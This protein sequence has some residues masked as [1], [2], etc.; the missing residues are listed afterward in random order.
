[1]TWKRVVASLRFELLVAGVTVVAVL[2]LRSRGLKMDG[3]TVGYIADATL[4]RWPSVLLLGLVLQ[5]LGCLVLWRSP[6]GWLRRFAEPRSLLAFAR[7]WLGLMV[8]TYT[9]LWLKI[10]VPLVNRA[11]WDAELWALD[12]WLHLGVSPTLFVVELFAGSRLV[13]WLDYWYALWLTTI[14]ATQ[15]YLFFDPD[16]RKRLNFAFACALL[17]LAAAWIY[18]ALPAVGP[19]FFVRDVFD[20]VRAAMPGAAALQD[21]LWQN[22][23][24]MIAGRDGGL[25]IQFKPFFAVAALPS[26]HV[27]AHFMFTLWARRHARRLWPLFAVATALTFVG[28]LL[29]GWHYAVD[30]YL[31][32]L[33]GWCAVRL[34]D[35][36]VPV[37]DDAAE[38]T[39]P[40]AGAAPA[41]GSARRNRARVAIGLTL[42]VYA[43]Y[44][45]EKWRSE[46]PRDF[47]VLWT[48]GQALEEMKPSNLYSLADRHAI[49][50]E[51]RARSALS[52]SAARQRSA[53]V[54]D[55]LEPV[56]TP[57][58]FATV[59]LVSSGDFETDYRRFHALSTL[60]YVGSVLWVAHLLGFPRWTF[61]AWALL[62]TWL[63]LPFYTDSGFANVGRIQLGLLVAVVALARRDA[64]WSDAL[65]GVTLAFS[66]LFKPTVVFAVVLLGALWGLEGRYRKLLRCAAAGRRGARRRPL[67]AGAA[68]RAGLQLVRVEPRP[69]R[70]P[71]DDRKPRR[72]VP[73]HAARAAAARDPAGVRRS[74]ALGR[75]GDPGADGVEA[76]AVAAARRKRSWRAR[77][78]R[79]RRRDLS[80]LG[81]R[82]PLALLRA[83]GTPGLV[84]VRPAGAEVANRAGRPRLRLDGPPPLVPVAGTHRGAQSQPLV[85]RR[86]RHPGGD[87]ARSPRKRTRARRARDGRRVGCRCSRSAL[88]RKRRGRPF[89]SRAAAPG[90]GRSPAAGR[91]PARRR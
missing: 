15:A 44:A 39:D 78:G 33:L 49:T 51:Y 68:L 41:A 6:L 57:F 42:C 47:Y 86:R 77:R 3:R 14:F 20:P 18:V 46:L 81:T 24:Q 63:F 21:K 13:P 89:F 29:T 56:S 53:E 4:R 30:G 10:S 9:Y 38:A 28:S 59:Q 17:W 60:L 25:L 50:E 87:R 26:V 37:P 71:A 1:V 43:V 12:R 69:P 5:L 74:P 48:M 65:A 58:L 90:R 31:G 91:R 82:R 54:W 34:A 11:L 27:G 52:D 88:D 67:A 72:R 55:L 79:R 61:V 32:M 84:G 66:L 64:W 16:R 23:L 70:D 8:M 7:V 62:L 75:A 45:V 40:Q 76:R 2:F 19:C 35:R 83:D 85:V 80:A 22:Y 36:W 73:D